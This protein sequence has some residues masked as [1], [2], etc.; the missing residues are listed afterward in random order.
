[1]VLKLRDEIAVLGAGSWGTAL[2]IHLAKNGNPVRLWGHRAEH[3]MALVSDR[4]NSRYLPGVAFPDML[5][6]FADLHDCLQGVRDVLIVVPS[7]AFAGLLRRVRELKGIDWRV[8][9]GT[10]GIDRDSGQLLSELT[11]SVCGHDMPMAVLSGPSFASEVARSL[12]TAV[13][14]AGNSADFLQSLQARFHSDVFRVYINSDFVG[15]QL[16]GVVKNILAIAVGVADG[17]GFGANARAALITRGMAE[18]ARLCDE[19][20]A[21]ADTLTGLA[22][23]GDVVLTCT[24]NE[25]RNRRFGVALGQGNKTQDI[26][27]DIGQ[28]IE[29]AHN[30]NQVYRLAQQYQIDMPITEQIYLLLSGQQDLDS[31]LSNLLLR[32]ATREKP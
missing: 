31:A 30:V 15:V 22:G 21:R 4:E 1:M 26:Y 10:K 17:M 14:V 29:G 16:C 9:W 3:C 11:A 24:G 7:V 25:S 18:M 6:V 2:A 20:G 19:L 32:R 28:E 27:R 23:L 12:P 13:S 5:S 8:V